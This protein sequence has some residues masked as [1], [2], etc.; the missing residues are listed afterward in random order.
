[1][2]QSV[3][4]TLHKS[5]TAKCLNCSSIYTLALTVPE[6]NLE[7][8]GNCHPFYTGQDTI[9]DSAGR[10]EKFQARMQKTQTLGAG[11]G[12]KT[13]KSRKIR[14][15]ISDLGEP[16]VVET[17]KPAKPQQPKTKSVAPSSSE[18]NTESESSETNE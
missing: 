11:T 7:I 12:K 13:K 2:A 15:S 8:C 4:V 6:I 14:Q 1:M 5:A 17:S 16:E 9:V 18:S 10:I 3:S